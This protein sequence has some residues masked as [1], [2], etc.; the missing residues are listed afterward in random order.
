VQEGSD[1]RN[2]L[3]WNFAEFLKQLARQRPLLIVLEDLHWADAS[4]LE[5]LHFLAR[6][7]ASCPVAIVC[8]H[9]VDADPPNDALL[10]MERS[11][12]SLSIAARHTIQPLSPTETSELVRRMF[13]VPDSI[14]RPFTG[15]LYEWTRGNPFFINEVLKTLIETGRLRYENGAWLGW[16]LD[17]LELPRSVR[18]AVMLRVGKMAAGTRQVA[19]LAAVLGGRPRLDALQAA[20]GLAESVLLT[21]LAELQDARM[22]VELAA[23]DVVS[24]E[25][26]HPIIRET[27]IAELGGGRAGM[28]HGRAGQALEQLYGPAATEHAGELAYHY[29]RALDR[30]LAA[31]AVHYLQAAGR[32]ALKKYANREALKYLRAA[33][34][35]VEAGAIVLTAR[36]NGQLVSSLAQAHQRLGETN[37]AIPLWERARDQAASGGDHRMVAEVERRLGLAYYFSG[38]AEAALAHLDAGIQAAQTASDD[39]RHAALGIARGVCLQELGWPNE[40]LESLHAA[41]ARTE[42][43]GSPQLR[44]SA[45]RALQLM[46]LWIGPPALARE[47]GERA[48]ALAAQAGDAVLSFWVHWAMATLGG[49]SG[50]AARL[51]SHLAQAR[52]IA[53]ELRSPLL[54]LWVAEVEIEYAFG[55]GRWDEGL[56]IGEHAISTARAL[57]QSL[58]LPRLLVWTAFIYLGRAEFARGKAYIDE[59]WIAAGLELEPAARAGVHVVLPAYIGR[60]AYSMAVG[61][62][63]NAIQTA[64]AAL[65]IVDATGYT[66]WAI[67]RLLPIALEASYHLQDIPRANAFGSRLREHS[68][69]FEHPLGLAWADA[70]DAVKI[71]LSGDPARAIELMRKAAEALESIPFLP[72]ATR[73]RRQLA[74]RLVDIGDREG[75]LRELRYVHEMLVKLGAEQELERS[76][77]QFREY[78]ARPPARVLTPGAIG[79]TRRELEIARAIVR[80]KSNKA[81][82][83]EMTISL[84]TVTTHVSNIYRK[85]GVSSRRELA[86]TIRAAELTGEIKK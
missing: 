11:L 56:A 61:D 44:A 41:L 65:A 7:T 42:R 54:Q 25:F 12:Q 49:L 17:R 59:A 38:R 14:S 43:D 31:K 24:Y 9:R 18:D 82:S 6:Q 30:Q 46:Y 45:H 21:V 10:R 3:Y 15:I 70:G 64:E 86:E 27:L 16:E 13:A 23:G 83:R 4:S 34:D 57:N 66:A 68:T 85:L 37:A 63:E 50:D 47:H 75:A 71:W 62:Y 72:D 79:L 39:A 80:H 8:T 29:A 35:R 74:G 77:A 19:E 69:R 73:L 51:T 20:T 81:I 78:G 48:L 28:L 26:V 36:D 53:E 84:R 22:L 60:A 76:R 40:A 32:H 33:L 67:H 55:D 52:R 58:L 1:F 5:L 2:R